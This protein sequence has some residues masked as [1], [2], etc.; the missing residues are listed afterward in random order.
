MQVQV[1]FI[2]KVKSDSD[3]SNFD[4]FEDD[5]LKILP[6]DKYVKE[7]ADFWAVVHARQRNINYF[8]YI[9]YIIYLPD[10]FSCIYLFFHQYEYRKKNEYQNRMF[11]L[12]FSAVVTAVTRWSWTFFGT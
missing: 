9:T 2:P 5:D 4:K 1:P 11:H 10:L 12:F 8:R 7:F 3:Y 6:K